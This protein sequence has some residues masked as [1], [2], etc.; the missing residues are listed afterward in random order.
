MSRFW[1]TKVNRGPGVNL[2]FSVFTPGLHLS[3]L[4]LPPKGAPAGKQKRDA[5]VSASLSCLLGPPSTPPV[6]VPGSLEL[7]RPGRG[8]F[9]LHEDDL[10]PQG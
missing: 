10:A 5:D 7:T 2:T 8:N 4:L 6:D 1:F 9:D 3:P